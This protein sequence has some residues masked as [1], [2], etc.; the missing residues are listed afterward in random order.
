MPAKWN[1]LPC[2]IFL[3]PLKTT[4]S[5][6]KNKTWNTVIKWSTQ[7]SKELVLMC[8]LKLEI[9]KQLLNYYNKEWAKL[10]IQTEKLSNNFKTLSNSFSDRQYPC[11]PQTGNWQ[12]QFGVKHGLCHC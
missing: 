9:L 4:G 7:G 1:I 11:A 12:F 6:V 2:F 10:N 3:I 8:S 5:K